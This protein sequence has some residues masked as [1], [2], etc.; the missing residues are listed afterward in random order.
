[1][2]ER[3]RV[4]LL[5]E[6]LDKLHAWSTTHCMAVAHESFDSRLL[7]TAHSIKPPRPRAAQSAQR[8]ITCCS[9]PPPSMFLNSTPPPVVLVALAGM[10]RPKRVGS[11]V[12]V[13]RYCHIYASRGSGV[14]RSFCARSTHWI[15]RARWI[16]LDL[17]CTDLCER[18]ELFV[19]ER[20]A[21]RLGCRHEQ[22]ACHSTV[23]ERTYGMQLPSTEGGVSRGNQLLPPYGK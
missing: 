22:V 16:K 18:A 14:G 10:T 2:P 9:G 23:H 20:L 11:G 17:A 12:V 3:P 7:H 21:L 4:L 8:V 13:L 5:R 19:A 1:M 6:G 15:K